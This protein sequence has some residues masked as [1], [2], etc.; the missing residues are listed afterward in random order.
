MVVAS[1][2]TRARL[3]RPLDFLVVADHA[4]NLGLAPTSPVW[5]TPAE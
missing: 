4:E 3:I 2:G 5:Y 1:S